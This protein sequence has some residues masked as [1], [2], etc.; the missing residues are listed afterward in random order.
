MQEEGSNV[1]YVLAVRMY[2]CSL[3][4]KSDEAIPRTVIGVQD[5]DWSM[6]G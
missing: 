1:G 2:F 5:R 6:K 3:L 4:S